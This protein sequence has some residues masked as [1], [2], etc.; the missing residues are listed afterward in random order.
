MLS[1]DGED[2]TPDSHATCLGRGV[3]FR[4]YAPLDPVHYCANPDMYGHTFRFRPA[5]SGAAPDPGR[6]GPE[7][8]N[9]HPIPAVGWSSRA[10]GH[11]RPPPTVR[12][13]WL[14]THLFA[15][16]T[17]P[18][19]A[20]PFMTRQLLAMPDPLRSGLARPTP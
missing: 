13:R 14:A 18:R 15:R 1:H 5:A 9:P 19:E 11:G 8:V 12:N 2:L 10:T 16:R 17:A 6:P 7:S 3:F 4:F 20:A